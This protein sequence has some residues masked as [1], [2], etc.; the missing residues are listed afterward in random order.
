MFFVDILIDHRPVLIYGHR[1][2]TISAGVEV[3]MT[4]IVGV[5][6]EAEK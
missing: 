3:P 5:M 1:F 2:F 4:T 6:P